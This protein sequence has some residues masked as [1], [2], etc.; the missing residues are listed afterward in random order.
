MSALAWT[1]VAAALPDDDTLVLLATDD[2]EVW[3]GYRD[4]DIWRSTDA[5]PVSERVTH[6]MHLP[7]APIAGA[8]A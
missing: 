6:W 7:P 2:R 8:A 5:M 4:G 3:P 1:D